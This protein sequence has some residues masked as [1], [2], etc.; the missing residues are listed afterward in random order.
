[1]LLHRVV[2]E[3]FRSSGTVHEAFLGLTFAL[4][5]QSLQPVL[6]LLIIMSKKKI[7]K[8]G[9]SQVPPQVKNFNKFDQAFD[10]LMW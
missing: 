9:A 5:G 3:C 8:P 2:E 10:Y 4:H 1:M 7:P 6:L